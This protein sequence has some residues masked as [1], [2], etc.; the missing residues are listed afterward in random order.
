MADFSFND[1]IRQESGG[2]QFDKA[3][4][5]LRSN[6]G[7]VGVAQVMPATGPE[8][9][10][11]AGLPWDP[12]RFE[13]DADYNRALGE[14]YHAKLARRFGSDIAA[15]AAYNGGPGR[16]ASKLQ[17]TNGDVNAAIALMPQETRDYVSRVHGVHIAGAR[18]SGRSS[19]STGSSS[20]PIPAAPPTAIDHS[21]LDNVI[22][23]TGGGQP[24]TESS[25]TGANRFPII[26]PDQVGPLEKAG[27][28][29]VAG[30]IANQT[31]FITQ[32]TNQLAQV[33]DS[34]RA[35]VE[36]STQAKQAINDTMT[37]ETQGLMDRV[38]PI[39]ELRTRLAAQQEK[40]ATMNPLARGLKGIF[41][42]NYNEH[43]LNE[44]VAR[45]DN[46]LQ[47][48]G[49]DYEY[50][51]KL[52]DRLHGLI[53]QSA[54]DANALDQ[55]TLQELDEKGKLVATSLQAAHSKFAFVGD[56]V[57]QQENLIRTRQAATD[58]LL[59]QMAPADLT[60]AM[61]RAQHSQTGTTV[62]DGVELSFGELR[63]RVV[64][65]Q[66]QDMAMRSQKIAV[67]RG[68]GDLADY[69][70]GKWA[71]TATETQI[72]A[73]IQANGNYNGMK[74]PIPILSQQL[75]VRENVKT[76]Q[77]DD[78][79]HGNQ[80]A[81][82]GHDL[83]SFHTNLLM[84]NSR[85]KSLFGGNSPPEL[86]AAGKQIEN[87]LGDFPRQINEAVKRGTADEVGVRLRKR[88]QELS[89]G[90]NAQID[91]VAER[92][93]SG[94]Q[95]AKAWVG[96]WLRG[97]ALD[98]NQSAEALY[99]YAQKGGLPSGMRAS[100]QARSAFQAAQGAA[101]SV[102]SE[103]QAQGLRINQQQRK[104]LILK[105]IQETVPKSY[106]SVGFNDIIG[107]IPK[108]AKQVGD[109]LGAVDPNDFAMARR[110]SETVPYAELGRQ[111]GV[112]PEIARQV[113][114][115]SYKGP[116][117]QKLA[118][119]VQ[120]QNLRGALVARQQSVFLE[121]LDRSPSAKPGFQPSVALAK[122]LDSPHLT[123][124]SS[125]YEAM[126]GQA[127]YGDFLGGSMAKGQLPETVSRWSH[128]IQQQVMDNRVAEVNRDARTRSMY[129]VDPFHRAEVILAA[130]P[131]INQEEESQLMAAI[132]HQ[133]PQDMASPQ[134]PLGGQNSDAMGAWLK[135]VKF[136]SPGLE[137]LRKIAAQRWDEMAGATDRA[138]NR[139]GR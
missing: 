46:V 101:Q 26:N 98:A 133:A 1:V 102:D 117:A 77:A 29:E 63:Q 128:A 96:T 47:T 93:A 136:Q 104:A 131:G 44:Q 97:G 87:E 83:D 91:K 54:G 107:T 86:V 69:H 53:D 120:S 4:N 122:F 19:F 106:T 12:K 84:L 76:Q 55:L 82:L 75:Q 78:I 135:S 105:R 39:M 21:W 64:G 111:L 40:L 71:E 24:V 114:A 20:M 56:M 73:A 99:Y 74:I 34:R 33:Q 110:Q 59:T 134:G 41:D 124:L 31:D 51:T 6:K 112:T 15:S 115:G 7:A 16:F 68:E 129:N 10:K 52:R 13:Q 123:N 57:S 88:V 79:L 18:G 3:G 89:D 126:A 45:T 121:S 80:M 95:G 119:R 116:D 132:R 50:I 2:H 62:I 127:S 9:A 48:V 32:F 61:N 125:R 22:S 8:A 139:S 113:I 103:I 67:E 25:T 17:Q 108:L 42:L 28:R 85:T 30:A 27:A 70:A 11:D 37:A 109:P 58:Q 49:H 23:A 60:A 72:R 66:A 100:P 81:L 38:K 130:I 65:L 36:Q 5:P 138:I 14:A 118:Q 35:R 92:H 137:R 94:D 43:Y 90:L